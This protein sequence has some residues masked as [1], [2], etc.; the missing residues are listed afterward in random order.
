MT[1]VVEAPPVDP[2]AA[3]EAEFAALTGDEPWMP[4]HYTTPIENPDYREGLALIL[5]A[6]IMFRFEANE[7]TR[8]DIWQK[9]LIREI[10]QRYPAG[11]PRAGQLVYRQA[12]VSMGRQN[13]KTVLGAVFALYGLI[14]MVRR[15]PEVIS[16]AARVDQAK[17]L[18]K[19]VRFCIETVPALQERFRPAGRAGI[20]SRVSSKPAS[21]EVK[22]SDGDGLQSFS[23]CLMLLDE[24]HLLKP[25]AWW[26][27][28][29][30]SSAQAKALVAGFTTAGDD[31]S[32]LLK[33]L[34]SI[35][36]EAVNQTD[37]HND[38]V[39]F[40][41]WT[42]DP[43]LELY[44]PLALIQAN[45]AI[46]CGRISLEDELRDGKSMQESEYRRY[47][48]NEFVSVE[49][50]WMALAA[51]RSAGGSGIP[52]GRYPIIVSFARTRGSWDRVAVFAST[53]IGDVVYVERV[54][55]LQYADT[56]WLERVCL[57]LAK[58]HTVEKFVTDSDT[59]R[60]TII[61]LGQQH[62]LPAEYLTRG[63]IANATA[64]VHSMVKTG[65]LIHDQDPE[66]SAQIPKAVTVNSGAGVV[67]DMTKSLGD[68]ESV[69]AMVMGAFMA[70]QQKEVVSP[71][72]IF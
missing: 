39:G 65:R 15:A 53:R 30:G 57:E 54:A 36:M 63:N 4:A 19:K 41:L 33:E 21:Y 29:L 1:A 61:A 50:T 31:N 48:R 7:D 45:P 43:A 32:K 67:L 56:E 71:I 23:G 59:M 8:L 2:M 20:T 72:S 46:A 40:F 9:W 47:R 18:Y 52:A 12:I 14:L 25:E 66:L 51:W 6:E 13:G 60:P 3:L 64:T 38:R 22:A 70:E 34:Y 26:A 35:G 27:L 16:I 68:I 44:D 58:H 55:T 10:L 42:A 49:N 28:V 37:G 5:L 17:N 62:G 24:L 11:H 69:Y